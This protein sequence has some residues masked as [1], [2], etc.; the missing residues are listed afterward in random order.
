MSGL[1][2]FQ[3]RFVKP[4]QIMLGDTI[5]VNTTNKDV[6]VSLV[7]TVTHR[8]YQGTDRVL[9]TEQ[10]VVLLRWN[11]HYANDRV[12][13]LSRPVARQT[14]LEIFETSGRL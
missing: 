6:S 7:G 10:G 5:R 11:P 13:L 2:A 1:R 12:T 9:Y 4:E 8:E 14:M 3:A